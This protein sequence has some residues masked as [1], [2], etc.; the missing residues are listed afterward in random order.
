MDT[1]P[2]PACGGVADATDGCRSCGRPPDRVAATLAKLNQAVAGL[3]AQAQQMAADRTQL[4]E[5]RARLNAR[6]IALTRALAQR[7]AD[8]AAAARRRSGRRRSETKLAAAPAPSIPSPVIPTQRA[9]PGDG[10]GPP[11][12]MV[13]TSTRSVRNTLLALGGVLLGVGAIVFTGVAFTT[14]RSA[15]ERIVTLALSTTVALLLPL[16]LARRALRATAETVAALGLLLVLLDGYAAYVNDLLG[17]QRV[18]A[19]TYAAV[20]CVLLAAIAAAYRLVTHLAAAQFAGLLALQPALPLLAWQ[21][22]LT[23]PAFAA[24]LALVAAQDVAAVA[25]LSRRR[26]SGATPWRWRRALRQLGWTLFAAALAAATGLAGLDL[27]LASTVSAAV[28]GALA[29]A[30]GAAVGVVGGQVDGRIVARQVAAGGATLAVIGA[31]TRIGALAWPNYT[32]VLAAALAAGAAIAAGVLPAA[33]R[34]GPHVA[35]LVVAGLTAV[36]VVAGALT[37]AAATVTAAVTP[38]WWVADLSQY[39]AR[40]QAESWQVPAA[41]LLLAIVAAVATPAPWRADALAVGG[42]VATFALPGTGAIAWW[43]V[44]LLDVAVAAVATT[45]GLSARSAHSAVLRSGAGIA[46]GLHAAATALARPGLTA[47]VFTT[48]TGLGAGISVLGTGWRHRFGPYVDRVADSTAGLATLALPVAVGT[49]AQLVRADPRV[50]LPVTM[51]AGAIG[52]AVAA[53]AQVGGRMPRTAT[54]GGALLA[55]VGCLMLSLGLQG[56]TLPDIALAAAL[57]VAALI[58]AGAR[59]FEV[60]PGAFIAAVETVP[61]ALTALVQAIEG[62]PAVHDPS[63][64]RRARRLDGVLVGAAAATVVLIWALARVA[65]VAVPGIGMVT[66]AA[67]VLLTATGVRLLPSA[68]QAGPRLGGLLVGGAVFTV[69]AAVAVAEAIG[70]L[71]AALPWWTGPH[72][73]AAGVITARYGWQVPATLVLAAA[74]AW[75]LIPGPRGRDAAFVAVSMAGLAAPVALGLNWWSPLLIAGTL[76]VV[77]GLGAALTTPGQDR[78]ARERLAL[79]ALLGLYATA[80]AMTTPITTAIAVTGIVAAGAVSAGIAELRRDGPG[81]VAGIASAAAL[82]AAPGAAAT[83]AAWAGA[84]RSGVLEAALLD[85]LPG[86]LVLVALRA[87]RAAWRAYPAFAVAAAALIVAGASALTAPTADAW[88]A[89]QIWA[90]LAAV[91]GAAAAATLRPDRGATAV[92]SSTA[93]P[94]ALVAAVG[95]APAWTGALFGPYR[96]FTYVWSGRTV[97]AAPADARPAAV[98]LALLTVFAIGT[99]VS[100]GARP[101]R[102]A[103]V[104]AAASAPLAALALVTPTALGAPADVVPWVALGIALATGFGAGLVRPAAAGATRLLRIVAGLIGLVVG[105]AGLAGALATRGGTLAM[106]GLVVAVAT[107]TGAVGRDPAIRRVAWVLASV[108][109]LALPVTAFAAASM[110]LRASAIWVL[111]VGAGLVM[112]AWPL[113]PGAPAAAGPTGPPDP[114]GAPTRRPGESALVELCAGLGAIGALGLALGL[115]P[116]A[117]AM[118]YAA[119]VLTIWGVLLGL[120][121]LRR[122]RAPAR[123]AWLA[124]AAAAAELAACWLLLYSA[125]VGLAEAY[126]LPF[127]A[128]ALLAGM[129]EL[130]RRPELSSWIAYGPAL[131]GGF[132]PSLALVLID[133]DPT[134]LTRRA[135]LFIGAVLTVIIGSWRRRQAPAVTGSTVAIVVALYHL[136]L[137]WIIGAV[138]GYL[139][140]AIAGLVLVTLG[141]TYERRLRRALRRMS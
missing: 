11:E 71:A 141:A 15:A 94:A 96:T 18:P 9:R 83:V 125:Q 81:L 110:P 132:L 4:M 119:V 3:D 126:T 34:R 97:T 76:A 8:E 105:G 102:A 70:P 37:T 123:R 112:L 16:L 113:A 33:V 91:V 130:R 21:A 88:R 19:R 13:E 2:C 27:G 99:A 85:C 23:R 80:A 139:L 64:P 127:A 32:V 47:G 14:D 61:A 7:L 140:V 17:V 115:P 22:G 136:V 48:L 59:A 55:A 58:T 26:P 78:A 75:A 90:A 104:V 31:L 74:A 30:A 49:L 67:M 93:A 109:A 116:T 72:T 108:A 66:T 95:S 45:S 122:D 68:W 84:T 54:A 135:A 73:D 128:V 87:N 63:L 107:L 89:V 20:L 42:L 12:R 43:A 82:L 36:V 60:S 92:L 121:A 138:A 86:L 39:A 120:A 38:R 41:A 103:R 28:P 118:P 46:L 52:L 101:G 56:S 57:C 40:V 124:R 5:R 134:H 117:E 79:A 50:L 53:V 65:A 69:A 62:D 131:A 114:A 10:A 133:I 100:L 51:L 6:R 77:A 24:V 44:P 25:M 29:L 129:V 98:T 137:L 1:Y 111:A 35:S 106:L